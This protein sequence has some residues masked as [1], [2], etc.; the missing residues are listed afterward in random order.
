MKLYPLL[1][2]HPTFIRSAS[3]KSLEEI[4]LENVINGTIDKD[5]IKIS[6]EVL[7]LQAEVALKAGRRQ[8]ALNFVRSAE[9]IE[10]PDEIMLNMYNQLRPYRST[11][12]EMLDLAKTLKETYQADRCSDL[13]LEALAVYEKRDL[14]K[15]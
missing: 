12:D 3:G 2:H 1:E 14:L 7:V 4:N 9:L 10:V 8:L 13:V 5:D 6:K 15:V 11:K